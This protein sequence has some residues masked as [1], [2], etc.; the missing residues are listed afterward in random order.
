MKMGINVSLDE[1]IRDIKKYLKSIKAAGIN[2]IRMSIPSS[3]DPDKINNISKE[4][5]GHEMK[6]YVTLFEVNSSGESEMFKAIS[7]NCQ[8]IVK[9]YEQ[10]LEAL[11]PDTVYAVGLI[12]NIHLLVKS[13]NLSKFGLKKSY[14][15]D[16]LNKISKAISD[17]GFKVAFP[18]RIDDVGR[19]VWEGQVPFDVYDIEMMLN[20]KTIPIAH[21]LDKPLIF[22]RA[23]VLGGYV[24]PASQV[25]ALRE[26]REL[27]KDI[28]DVAY[29]WSDKKHEK[30]KWSRDGKMVVDILG[31]KL[32]G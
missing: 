25:K 9:R 1:N 15:A 6:A 5:E 7:E 16:V 18:M 22:G 32:I 30:F 2:D 8:V 20:P 4:I 12:G 24:M 14:V 19:K 28:A 27:G 3:V 13:G 21:K 29:L 23:G 10:V 17:K 11:V 26:L 31:R